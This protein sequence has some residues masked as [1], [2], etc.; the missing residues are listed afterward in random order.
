MANSPKYYTDHEA[1]LLMAGR[2]SH[3]KG[4]NPSTSSNLKHFIITIDNKTW[5]HS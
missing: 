3:S 2:R 1:Q 4:A 5:Y